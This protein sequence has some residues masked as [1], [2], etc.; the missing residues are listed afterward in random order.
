MAKALFKRMLC[1]S[2][3]ALALPHAQSKIVEVIKTH[4][5][6]G[7]YTTNSICVVHE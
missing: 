5:F 2:G 4:S 3:E 7:I 1:Q 6:K